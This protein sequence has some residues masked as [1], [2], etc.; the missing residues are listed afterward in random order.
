M[1]YDK[2]FFK[3]IKQIKQTVRAFKGKAVAT[4]FFAD[5]NTKDERGVS[6]VE[7]AVMNNYGIGCPAR[8]FATTTKDNFEKKHGSNISKATILSIITGDK[9]YGERVMNNEAKQFAAEFREAIKEWD[10][11]P[12][13]PSTIADKGFNDPLVRTGEMRDAPEGRIVNKKK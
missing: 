8:P 9:T 7:K 10:T 2:S 1:P 12:N 4:G 3:K 6:L 13:A 11:P 5:K